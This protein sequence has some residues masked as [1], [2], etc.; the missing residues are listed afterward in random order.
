[1][2]V[3]LQQF[4]ECSAYEIVKVAA[5][6]EEAVRSILELQP[7]LSILDI[8]MPKMDGIT[9][10]RQLRRAN[11]STRVVFLTLITAF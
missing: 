5:D 9:V 3:W 1:M 6:G 4:P 10:A 2:I 7:D 8:S 11:S